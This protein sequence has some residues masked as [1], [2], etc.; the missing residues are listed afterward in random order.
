MKN[1]FLA[2]LL[3]PFC[4]MAQGGFE[5]TGTIAGVPENSRVT[6][7]NVNKPGDTAASAVVTIGTFVL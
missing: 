3:L 4:A 1:L 6:L 2:M 7:T 5:I